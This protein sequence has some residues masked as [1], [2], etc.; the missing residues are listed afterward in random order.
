MPV[1][2]HID[3]Y[4][5]CDYRLY[6]QDCFCSLKDGNR[7]LSQ[8]YVALKIGLDPSNLTKIINGKRK[9]SFEHAINFAEFLKLSK[10]QKEYFELLVRYDYAQ[11]ETELQALQKKIALRQRMKITAVNKKHAGYFQKW[12]H[13]VIRE[14]LNIMPVENHYML[15][16]MLIPKISPFEAKQ[17]FEMLEAL[18]MITKDNNGKYCLTS[19]FITPDDDVPTEVIHYF[20][21]QMIAL[22]KNSLTLDKDSRD[23][24]TMTLSFSIEDFHKVKGMIAEFRKQLFEV[25]QNSSLSPQGVFQVNIQAFPVALTNVRKEE[26]NA[27]NPESAS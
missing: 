22:A 9:L 7:H 15:S 21:K 6:L 25:A 19:K 10:S 20:Q 12:Y 16:Q 17:A 26:I 27:A 8:R 5:Y 24:S 11:N 2:S 1:K 4:R 13:V 18:D 14:L 3:I 23:V